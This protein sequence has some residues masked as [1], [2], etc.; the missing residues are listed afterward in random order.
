MLFL[1]VLHSLVQHPKDLYLWGIT[2]CYEKLVVPLADASE[3]TVQCKFDKLGIITNNA[4]RK[5]KSVYPSL[6]LEEEQTINDI[7][8]PW[9]QQDAWTEKKHFSI[10][11]NGYDATTKLSFF[12]YFT[13]YND[14]IKQPA[15][16][17]TYHSL[18]LKRQ[19][20]K[21][22]VSSFCGITD[23]EIEDD[24]LINVHT[25]LKRDEITREMIEATVP[26]VAPL[27]FDST[28]LLKDNSFVEPVMKHIKIHIQKYITIEDYIGLNEALRALLVG[29]ADFSAIAS[30]VYQRCLIPPTRTPL[31]T[32]RPTPEVVQIVGKNAAPRF[33][34]I[35]RL[36]HRK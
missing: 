10:A 18:I 12:A 25:N 6:T 13:L 19:N 2:H 24:E 34:R 1:A 20:E 17:I 36:R 30:A 32:P 26:A 33:R 31:P 14:G 21:S 22:K 9:L 11:I 16:S 3:S 7:L 15:N 35:Q 28:L 8:A 27:A 23:F 4:I 29:K 5:L